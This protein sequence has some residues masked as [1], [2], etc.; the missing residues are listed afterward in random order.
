M[1]LQCGIA[2]LIQYFY[3]DGKCG[4]GILAVDA[5]GRNEQHTVFR[6]CGAP[7]KIRIVRTE[8][9]NSL[10]CFNFLNRGLP[11][12][13]VNTN[14]LAAEDAENADFGKSGFLAL[15]RQMWDIIRKQYNQL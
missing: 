10:L 14:I 8:G 4:V 6:R 3:F 5:G 7:E 2:R 9:N 1:S 11:K 12:A 15:Y 13:Q